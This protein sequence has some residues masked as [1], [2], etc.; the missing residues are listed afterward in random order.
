MGAAAATP[1]VLQALRERLRDKDGDVRRAA[2]EALGAM[3][4]AA[5]TSEVLQ[6]LTELRDKDEDEYVREAAALALG[7]MGEAED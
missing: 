6:A 3:G 4:A 7:K 2:A 1:E 5:A